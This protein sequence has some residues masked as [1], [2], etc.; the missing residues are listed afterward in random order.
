MVI[1]LLRE[2][3]ELTL[4][5]FSW[6]KLGGIF[7]RLRKAKILSAV[8]IASYRWMGGS[9]RMTHSELRFALSILGRI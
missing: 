3:S 9:Q 2:Y 1:V 5:L 7:A 4:P 8:L 6:L